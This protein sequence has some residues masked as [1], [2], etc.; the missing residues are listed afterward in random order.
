[1]KFDNR[2]KLPPIKFKPRSK[3]KPGEILITYEQIQQRIEDL[4][5]SIAKKYKGKKLLIVGILKGAFKVVSDLSSGLHK[6]GLKDL[7]IS[8]IAMKSYPD[9]TRAKYQPR[10]IQDM[11]INPQGREVLLVDDVLDTGRSLDVIHN[12]IKDRKAKSIKSFAL[13]DKPE[14]RQIPYKADYVGFTI[15][16][17]WIQ[18]YG[19][20]TGEV[21]RAEPNIIVGPYIYKRN[22]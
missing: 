16:D 17:V 5:P 10:I 11:D 7:E 14:R 22:A 1:M 2:A 4:A 8:F 15:P 21:G 20:D 19:M 12:L 18:G 3:Y 13:I 6:A 9:G